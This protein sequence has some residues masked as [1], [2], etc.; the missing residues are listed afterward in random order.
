[1]LTAAEQGVRRISPEDS[2]SEEML[3]RVERLI[4]VAR[5]ATHE[6]DYAQAIR[7]SYYACLL[8]GVALPD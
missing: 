7:G 5:N 8:L 6:G 2:Y 4:D 1:L 3:V